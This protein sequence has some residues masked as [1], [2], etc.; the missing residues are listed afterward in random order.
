MTKLRK[1][2]SRNL[3]KTKKITANKK[4][5]DDFRKEQDKKIFTGIIQIASSS[6]VFGIILGG[7]ISFFYLNTIGFHSIFAEIINQPSSLIAVTFVFGLFI[8]LVFISFAAPCFIFNFWDDFKEATLILNFMKSRWLIIFPLLFWSLIWPLVFYIAFIILIQ[9][10]ESFPKDYLTILL[11]VTIALSIIVPLCLWKVFISKSFWREW[12]S[13]LL[14]ILYLFIISLFMSIYPLSIFVLL[15]NWMP[16]GNLQFFYLYAVGV[17]LI[18]NLLLIANFAT[19]YTKAQKH[20]YF[21][22][23]IG[24]TLCLFVLT[25]SFFPFH[26]NFSAYTLNI[27][28]FVELPQN[29][30]WYLLHNNFQKNDGSQESSGIE[31]KDLQRLKQ[32][33]KQPNIC[34]RAECARAEYRNNALYGY[35]AWNLGKTKVFCPATVSN[36]TKKENEQKKLSELSEKCLVIGTQFLQPIPKNYIGID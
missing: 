12:K 19:T 8:L 10:S 21:M 13:W 6:T 31:P 30:S 11:Y 26:H 29:A 18:L 9:I 7:V 34:D 17:L 14:F 25:S 15:A 1:N 35:M 22:I 16:E 28:R 5:V 36:I 2:F 4:I 3:F 27:V 23:P 32:V 20:K 33:F 24:S